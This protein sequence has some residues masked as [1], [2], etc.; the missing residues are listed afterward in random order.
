MQQQ[1][2]LSI[3]VKDDFELADESIRYAIFLVVILM[4]SFD[5]IK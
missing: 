4:L 1:G 5:F 2:K 3:F